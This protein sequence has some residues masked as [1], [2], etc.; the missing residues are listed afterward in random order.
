MARRLHDALTMTSSFDPAQVMLE[1]LYLR[2]A[3]QGDHE[4]FVSLG[5]IYS[6]QVYSIARNLSAS[7]DV[8]LRLTR[9]AFERAWRN[10]STIPRQSSFRVFVSRFLVRDAVSRL[11]HTAAPVSASL[12]RFSPSFDDDRRLTGSPWDYANVEALVGRPE[13][14]E[15]LRDALPGLEAEDRAAFVLRIV[16]DLPAEEV[17]AILEV[18]ASLAQKRAHWA[19]LLLSGYVRHL[20]G[21]ATPAH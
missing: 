6:E 13:V 18:P 17:A 14:I 10:V 4:A 1:E 16:E 20:A 9:R 21:D 12:E 2:R 5:S 7:D 19:C 8:A 15:R 3:A 11:R